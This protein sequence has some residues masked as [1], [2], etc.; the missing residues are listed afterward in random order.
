LKTHDT[1]YMYSGDMSTTGTGTAAVYVRISSDPKGERAGVERQRADCEKLARSLGYES[2]R[3]YEDNDKSAYSG[4]PRPA[5]ERMLADA[6]AGRI[7]TLIVWAIDRLYRRLTDLERIVTD[8]DAAKVSVHAVKSG[9]L[10]LSTADGRLHARLL[11]SVA[12]H[13]SEKKSER[14]AARA[15]QRAT[16]ERRMTAAQR[17]FGWKHTDD[18][19]RPDETE[20]P[21]LAAAYADILDGLSL[22][23]THKRLAA[24]IDVG[25]MT[26]TT[27]GTIL[28]NCRNGGLVR[29]QG[30]IVGESADG[31]QIVDRDTFE[32]AAAILNDPSR[33]TSPGRP[34]NTWLGGGLLTCGRCGSNM[35][36]GRKGDAGE[37]TGVYVCSRNKHLTRRRD[38]IDS[39]VLTQAGDVLAAMGARGLL[40]QATAEDTGAHELRQRIAAAEDRL[41]QLAALLATGDL[42]PADFAA[43]TAKIR[44][45]MTADADAL[46]ARAQRPA[47]ATLAT[48]Q[49]TA[50]AWQAMI[51][52]DDR[53]TVRAILRDLIEVIVMGT[54]RTARITWQPWTG[55][56]PS[57]IPSGPWITPADLT[58]RRAKVAAL[59]RQGNNIS[60]IARALTMHRNT[61]RDDL[62]HEGLYEGSNA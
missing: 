50:A 11:G 46:T 42:D 31:C 33:R 10:D 34:A 22:N 39:R 49:D 57:T 15:K 61:V 56:E 27:L 28:R 8:L 44:A 20:A 12:Q 60:Q 38:L 52:A 45:G 32:R 1:G 59:R 21:A 40:A 13:E 5:F 53:D 62:K 29:Y 17:P 7:D 25:K 35:A 43:A 2:V 41:D 26:A 54:D 6:G 36:A 18:G 55:L 47:L 58:D 9:D 16:V 19:L 37:R 3:V 51:E 4:K 23:A 48:S 14:I 24:R 30:Q